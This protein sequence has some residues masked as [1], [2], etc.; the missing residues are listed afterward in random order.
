MFM[1]AFSHKHFIQFTIRLNST[2]NKIST[3]AYMTPVLV[4][5]EKFTHKKTIKIISKKRP[6]IVNITKSQSECC[7]IKK[8]A[9]NLIDKCTLQ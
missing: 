7:Q 5:P 6:E 1:P 8:A 4:T 3:S 2:R 9:T